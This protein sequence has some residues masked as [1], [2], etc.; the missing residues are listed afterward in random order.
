MCRSAVR[1][2]RKLL[3]F[4]FI[5]TECFVTLGGQSEHVIAFH[6]ARFGFGDACFFCLN[7]FF[8]NDAIYACFFILLLREPQPADNFV[9]SLIKLA[10]STSVAVLFLFCFFYQI[11]FCSY[12][13]EFLNDYILV[14]IH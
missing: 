1:L 14:Q 4:A 7:L 13:S 5:F 3:L 8:S 10:L 2:A 9:F 11:L 6:C 12:F